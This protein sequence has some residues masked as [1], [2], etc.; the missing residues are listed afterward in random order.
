MDS[1]WHRFSFPRLSGSPLLNPPPVGAEA[2]KG[3]RRGKARK[4]EPARPQESPLALLPCSKVRR[5]SRISGLDIRGRLTRH[6]EPRRRRR[7]AVRRRPLS[8]ATALRSRSPRCTARW[9]LGDGSEARSVLFAVDAARGGVLRRWGSCATP[10]RTES[11]LDAPS[12]KHPRS[13]APAPAPGVR[14]PTGGR[15]RRPFS[16]GKVRKGACLGSPCRCFSSRDYV[17]PPSSILP[18]WGRRSDRG[19]TRP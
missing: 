5:C 3:R 18:R 10:E 4:E 2:S 13:A 9:E 14:T 19:G 16:Q 8:P 15:P 1:P 7:R 17:V 11:W 6:R 12:V